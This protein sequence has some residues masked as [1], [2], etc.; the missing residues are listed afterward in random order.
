MTGGIYWHYV[1]HGALDYQQKI[2]YPEYDEVDAWKSERIP[3]ESTLLS[4]INLPGK[5]QKLSVD[6]AKCEE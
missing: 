4:I 6:W 5:L 3:M 2:Q 1:V